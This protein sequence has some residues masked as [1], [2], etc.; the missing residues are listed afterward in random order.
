MNYSLIEKKHNTST[1][2]SNNEHKLQQ[3]TNKSNTVIKKKHLQDKTHSKIVQQQNLNL[4]SSEDN[5]PLAVTFIKPRTVPPLTDKLEPK[6]LDFQ[7]VNN[8]FESF[9][10]EFS[11]FQSAQF[12]FTDCKNN[13]EFT[14]FQ[15]AFD[16]L[17]L[18]EPTKNI[19]N[20][21]ELLNV[22]SIDAIS[23]SFDSEPNLI[24]Y[25][26]DDIHDKYKAFR[27]AVE[28]VDT[29]D[30]SNKYVIV[31]QNLNDLLDVS[32]TKNA[33]EKVKNDICDEEFGDFLCV[34][35]VMNNKSET[36]INWKNVQ[37]C[38]SIN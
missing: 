36:E 17:S 3:T 1:I 2:K 19:E 9:D 24:S 23:N 20:H 7:P 33:E 8:N 6:S 32:P 10:D 38:S 15:S 21:V 14:N 34:E 37:V 18:K 25:Q 26:D 4:I 35:E 13:Q 31:H 30:L 29:K 27:M 22:S 16:T 11:E 5:D 28:T 12:S